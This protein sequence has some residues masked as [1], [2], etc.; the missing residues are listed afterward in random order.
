[1]SPF[2]GVCAA[3][4]LSSLRTDLPRRGL[5][6]DRV[7]ST[8]SRGN[9]LGPKSIGVATFTMR[10]HATETAD[11]HFGVTNALASHTKGGLRAA[12]LADVREL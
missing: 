1:M 9:I 6:S 7:R 4:P 5:G 11:V 12:D 2:A 3:E 10:I 8:K